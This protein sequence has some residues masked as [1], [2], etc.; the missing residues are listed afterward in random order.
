MGIRPSTGIY[1]TADT[2]EDLMNTTLTISI[3]VDHFRNKSYNYS[4]EL[5]LTENGLPTGEVEPSD[6][7]TVDPVGEWAVHVCM[8]FGTHYTHNVIVYM[9]V[10]AHICMYPIHYLSS[11]CIYCS[12]VYLLFTQALNS[13]QCTHTCMS[14]STLPLHSRPSPECM[15]TLYTVQVLHRCVQG[16]PLGCIVH[17]PACVSMSLHVHYIVLGVSITSSSQACYTPS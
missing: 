3:T 4:C 14:T 17:T 13:A 8:Q 1:S 7:V 11:K 2:S 5:V 16:S 9:Y 15:C 6:N 10:I 12:V